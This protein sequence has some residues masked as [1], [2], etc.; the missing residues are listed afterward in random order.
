MSGKKRGRRMYIMGGVIIP[1]KYCLGFVYKARKE[2]TDVLGD[3]IKPGEKIV[4]FNN[5]SMGNEV[6]SLEQFVIDH[7]TGEGVILGVKYGKIKGSW[8]TI[9]NGVECER[10]FAPES[11]RAAQQ[12]K[13]R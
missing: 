10:F 9:K 13:D 7:D 5:Y 1:A 11:Y 2:Y 12:N 6:I 3:K 8:G 4:R